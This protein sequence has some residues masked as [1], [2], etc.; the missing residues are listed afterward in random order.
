MRHLA[1]T[2]SYFSEYL[3]SFELAKMVSFTNMGEGTKGYFNG[4]CY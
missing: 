1:I 4:K 2:T 3:R